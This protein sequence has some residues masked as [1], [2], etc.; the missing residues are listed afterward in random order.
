MG[1]GVRP[2]LIMD[3][4]GPVLIAANSTVLFM[5][6]NYRGPRSLAIVE[7]IDPSTHP[8]AT[9]PEPEPQSESCPTTIR[10]RSALLVRACG[11][12]GATLRR[13]DSSTA[14]R[15]GLCCRG[16]PYL[17]GFESPYIVS[18]QRL[19]ERQKRNT[20]GTD[21]RLPVS[22]NFMNRRGTSWAQA[23]RSS[24]LSREGNFRM[25]R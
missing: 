24:I 2:T 1:S 22:A 4:D 9:R 5:D 20:P 12:G 21:P 17:R 18:I 10:L 8:T 11:N 25:G 14:Y 16:P 6:S 13:R 7:R 23:D 15:S 3:P 19:L